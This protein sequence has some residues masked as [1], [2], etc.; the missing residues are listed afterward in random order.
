MPSESSLAFRPGSGKENLNGMLDVDRRVETLP[1][2]GPMHAAAWWGCLPASKMQH[3]LPLKYY[4]QMPMEMGK[5]PVLALGC[6]PE[7]FF[8]GDRI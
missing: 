1:S 6:F 5:W 7:Y 4:F 3:L 8:D 2:R